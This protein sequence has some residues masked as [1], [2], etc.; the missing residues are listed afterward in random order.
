M[1]GGLLRGVVPPESQWNCPLGTGPLNVDEGSGP[2]RSRA[3]LILIGMPRCRAESRRVSF[4]SHNTWRTTANA[5]AVTIRVKAKTED[6]ESLSLSPNKGPLEVFDE[7]PISPNIS[8]DMRV[9]SDGVEDDTNT[10]WVFMARIKKK[11]K[12][13]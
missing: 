9:S 2:Q 11:K 1:A 13:K 5:A 12:E 3:D 4:N 8:D 6:S 7:V 10:L